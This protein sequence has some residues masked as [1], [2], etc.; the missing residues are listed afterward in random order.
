MHEVVIGNNNDNNNNEMSFKHKPLAYTR[1]QHTLQ[2]NKK[3][4]LGYHSAHKNK[5]TKKPR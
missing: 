3:Y 4:H 5:Q 2:K 1:A